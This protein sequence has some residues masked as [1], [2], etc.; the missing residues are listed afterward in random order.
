MNRE[1]QTDPTHAKLARAIQAL[2]QT[3][4]KLASIEAA[5]HEPIAIIGMGCH[6]DSLAPILPT[7][8][9]TAVAYAFHGGF[10]DRVD[11]FEPAFFGLSPREVLVMDPAHR[12]LLETAWQ[13]LE[14]ANL[15]PLQLFNTEMGVFVGNAAS[16]YT[17]FCTEQEDDLYK[18]TGNVASTAAGRLSYIFGITGPCV[19]LDTACSSSLVAIH[20]ACQSLRTGECNAAL[21]GGVNLILEAGSSA[22]FA[23]GNMLSGTARCKSFDAAADGYVRGEGCGMLVLKRLSDAQANGD[24]I[25]AVIRGTAVNQDGPSG[26]LTVPNGPAQERVIRRALA[27]GKLNPEQVG[28]IEAHGTGTPLGDPIEIGALG[29][30][31]GERQQPLYV[32][33][34]KTNIGHLE[35]AAGV[36][37][38]M[39]LVL[40][41]QHGQLPPHLHFQ[42][43]NPHIDWAATPVRVPTAP[44]PWPLSA[45]AGE[46]I[47][48]VSSFGF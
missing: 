33:S 45:A 36:A 35:M 2:Q 44:T 41:I 34:V 15:V 3:R 48:G 6:F 26:G 14:D 30:V 22:M 29:A 25:L 10:L 1:S 18:A 24:R 46:R 8:A 42:T 39:K 38:L 32:G 47:G 27:D 13:A 17:Q 20:L 7:A 43:P 12:L 4:L 23:N 21:A 16:G 28:Y 9:T 37:G 31:F 19:S 5:Q 40:A 11:E